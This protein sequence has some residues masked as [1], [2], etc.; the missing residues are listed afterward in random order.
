LKFGKI[1]TARSS[2]AFSKLIALLAAAVAV[3][4]SAIRL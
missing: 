4:A 2:L 1:N 3:P